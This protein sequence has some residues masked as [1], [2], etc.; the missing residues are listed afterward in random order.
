MTTA[1]QR[2]QLPQKAQPLFD[3]HRFKSVRGG[4]DG[5]KSRS[6]ATILL[7]LG[8]LPPD[9]H[10][11]IYGT[12]D[13]EGEPLNQLNVCARETMESIKDSVHRLLEESIDRMGMRNSQY[14]VER[15]LIYHHHT[16]TEFV[17]KGLWNNPDALKSLEGATRAWV[18]EAQGVSSDSWEKLIPTVRKNGSE[19][20]LTWNPDLETDP[21]W[22]RFVVDPP[23]GC[24][25]IQMNFSDNP[26]YSKVLTPDREKM[27]R[28]R[29]ADYE[30][31]WLGRPKRQVDGAIYATEIRLA[32]DQGRI[33]KVPY[34]P[35]VPVYTGWDLGDGDMTAIWF[36]QA[37]MGQFRFIDYEEDRHKPLSHYLTLLDGKG[38]TY[39]KD[40]FPWDAASKMLVGSFEESMRAR[41][42]NVQ[43]LP[44]Q[45]VEAGIDRV[46]EMM[47]TAWWDLAKCDKGIQRLRH[48]RYETTNVIDPTTGHPNLKRTPLHDDNSHG[49]DA[50]RTLAMGHMFKPKVGTP[51]TAAGPRGRVSAWS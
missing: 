42:R 1:T 8:A 44:R 23:P 7:E 9:Q 35:G 49:C 14:G 33:G 12:Y 48:Y 25:D 20:W 28:D 6:V 32:E 2:I 40:Y 34:Q 4:R 17:F 19:V 5:A 29:P 24:I 51:S 27:M 30:H 46:R 11:K 22:K 43:V 26:W 50:K 31:I 37:V 3:P 47:G 10:A 18:E 36:M 13:E 38:Y 39:A 21:T 45:S 41:G 15:A 16:K